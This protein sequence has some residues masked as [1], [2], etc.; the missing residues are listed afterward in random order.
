MSYV[1][2]IAEVSSGSDAPG[3]V[4]KLEVPPVCYLVQVCFICIKH[5]LSTEFSS[6][7]VM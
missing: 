4:E 5:N 2:G 3:F 6:A 7:R 1:F